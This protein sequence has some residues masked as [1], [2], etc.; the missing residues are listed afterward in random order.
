MFFQENLVSVIIPVFNR[1]NL[2]LETLQSLKDQTYLNWEAILVDD[3]STDGTFELVQDLSD[4]DPRIKSYKREVEP[5][6]AS[7]CRNYGIEVCN[8]K[9][10]FFLDS[11]DILAPHCIQE[12]VKNFEENPGMDF[13]VFPAFIF[14]YKPGDT[15]LLWNIDKDKDDIVRFLNIDVPWQTTATI[16]KKETLKKLGPWDHTTS[17]WE[18]ADFHMRALIMGFNYK[19][20]YFQPDYFYRLNNQDKISKNDNT[21]EQLYA[22]IR[23]AEKIYRYLK[24]N[25]KFEG[26]YKVKL[27][28][29]YMWICYSFCRAKHYDGV[30]A[31]CYSLYNNG[32]LNIFSYKIL[33][34]FMKFHYWLIYNSFKKKSL[35]NIRKIMKETLFNYYFKDIPPIDCTTHT[36]LF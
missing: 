6:G 9:Y 7:S 15:E 29:F 23:L 26:T 5:K 32:P 31:V 36:Q 18:D 25:N 14:E 3:G 4:A 8:G 30:K 19:K 1:K 21:I 2:L 33:L 12:R 35:Q 24:N 27:F 20:I 17:A 10:V 22:R 28:N 34:F 13:L 11:D 16:F